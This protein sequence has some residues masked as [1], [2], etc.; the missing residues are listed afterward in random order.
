MSV[1]V[2][3]TALPV[4]TAVA[5]PKRVV[6][7]LGMSEAL[8]L[9]SSEDLDEVDMVRS[10]HAAP[11]QP[12]DM[13][14]RYKRVWCG[15]GRRAEPARD[16]DGWRRREEKGRLA[17]PWRA[18][19]GSVDTLVADYCL[20]NVSV[21]EHVSVNGREKQC[22][23][24]ADRRRRERRRGRLDLQGIC[25]RTACGINARETW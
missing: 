23:R 1:V 16:G 4:R 5:V 19:S 12:R 14:F 15:E 18:K 13:S 11:L 20:L 17:Y 10:Q 22:M 2:G 7:L 8:L 3:M 6:L 24:G 9:V 25:T 21:A